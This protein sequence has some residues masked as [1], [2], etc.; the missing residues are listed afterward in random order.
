MELSVITNEIHES[1]QRLEKGSK[2]LFNLAKRKAETEKE[3]RIA[4]AKEILRLKDE[5]KPATLI[6]DLARGNTAELKYERDLAETLW[7]SARDSLDAIKAQQMGLQSILRI[8]LEI[9]NG[10]G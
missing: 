2:E 5:G 7:T 1:G 3:Y 6:P 10:M 8:Q 4:L 9:P